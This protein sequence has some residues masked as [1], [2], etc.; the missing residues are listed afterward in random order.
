MK[1]HWSRREFLQISSAAAGAMGFREWPA[2]AE[3][4][5]SGPFRGTICFFSKPVPQLSWRELGRNAKQAGFDGVDLTV[6]PGGHVLPER[7]ET[8]LPQAIEAIRAEGLAVP[9]ITTALL[10]ADDPAAEPT[11]RAASRLSIPYLKPGYY[12]WRFVNVV[13]E[14]EEAGRSLRSLVDLAGRYGIQVGYHNHNGYIGAAIWDMARVIE[15]LD[16]TRCGFYF[17]L[18]HATVDGGTNGWKVDANLVLPRLKMIG[19]KDFLWTKIGPHEW[20]PDA[21]PMGQGMVPWKEFLQIL[22][23]SNFHGPI[24]LQQEFVIA[25]AADDQG[26]AVSRAAIPQVMESARQNLEYLRSLI[27][28]SYQAA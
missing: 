21:C 27:R 6:R 24:S 4:A 8:D 15:P 18:G 14:L 19:A 3:P 7:V 1:T 10:S 16:P 12:H 22:A 17:D 13:A 11:M 5:A 9:M 23:K 2:L 25:G 26:I 20:R 28:E